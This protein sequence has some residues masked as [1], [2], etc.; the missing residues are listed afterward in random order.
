MKS[1]SLLTRRADLSPAAFKAYYEDIHCWLGMQHF[2]FTRYTRNHLAVESAQ[3]DFDCLS[4][5]GMEPSFEGGDV[6]RSRSRALMLDDERQFMITERIR[7]AVMREQTL[8]GT[9][10]DTLGCSRYVLLFQR[11]DADL[12]IYQAAIAEAAQEWIV[13]LSG[14]RHA[15]LDLRVASALSEFPYDALLWLTL[16]D[17]CE[18]LLPQAGDWP[19]LLAVVAVTT[20]ATPA[21]TLREN[22]KAYLP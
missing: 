8:L 5:F 17:G 16:E 2:P 22:F 18:A 3:V 7:V 10:D 4:E 9:A 21:A 12:E 13:D 19:G 6:M 20:H 11:T 1:I 14:V 15:S